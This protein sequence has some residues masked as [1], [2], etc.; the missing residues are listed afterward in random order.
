MFDFD[1]PVAYAVRIEPD[2]TQ[3][4]VQL[5]DI[6]VAGSCDRAPGIILDDRP[7]ISAS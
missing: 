1:T 5:Y 4:P 2:G 7:F 6:C 3:T